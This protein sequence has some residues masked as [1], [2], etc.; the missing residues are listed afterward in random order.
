MRTCLKLKYREY[1]IDKWKTKYGKNQPDTF[2]SPVSDAPKTSIKA[3]LNITGKV[4][5]RYTLV[6]Q[7]IRRRAVIFTP[8]RFSLAEFSPAKGMARALSHRKADVENA[9]AVNRLIQEQMKK[10]RSL[11]DRMQKTGKPF[12]ARDIATL[13]RQQYDHCYVHSQRSRHRCDRIRN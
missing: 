6:F 10:L 3:L 9:R 7:I 1:L 5:E 2:S 4:R 8:Y 11:A 13:Y 12:T